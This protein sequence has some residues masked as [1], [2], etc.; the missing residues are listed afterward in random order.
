M[1]KKIKQLGKRLLGGTFAQGTPLYEFYHKG[2]GV[3]A[4]TSSGFPAAKMIVV[5]VTGTNG[6][7]A[8]CTMLAHIL[9]AAGKK[10]GLMT[11]VNFWINKKKWVNESKMTT[12]N[13]FT[14]QSLLRRMVKAGCE[15]AV[16]ETS[17]HALAQHRTWGI[18]YDVAVFTNLTQDHL[19]YHHTM[20]EYRRSKEKLFKN[21]ASSW[22]KPGVAKTIVL[23]FDDPLHA[24]FAKYPAE[25]KLFFSAQ[26]HQTPPDTLH[27]K[28]IH[29]AATGSLFTLVSPTGSIKVQLQIPGRFNI[30]NALAAAT[31]AYALGFPLADIKRGL[32]SVDLI[33]GRM[34]Y[35]KAGQPFNV[36]SDY[37][38]TPDGYEKSLSSIRQFTE[39][40][41]ITVFGAAGDRDKE[42]RPLIGR[43]A[44]KYADVIV[45]TEEDPGSEDP[46]Q[47]IEAIR[48]GISAEKFQESKNLFIILNRRAA[49]QHALSLAE[50]KDSVVLLALG[51]Q[52]KMATPTGLV[53]YDEREYAKTLLHKKY[54]S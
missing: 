48:A 26:N 6:K 23:N 35:I 28:E 42:K 15:Y 4:A 51:A 5:G 53:D 16:V 21:L 12:D 13:P 3:W 8:T 29:L 17:S 1:I 39:G 52:T 44:S 33:P 11:T 18:F 30:E 2:R 34:E 40:R 45:L 36:I 14:T 25:Q 43:I 31:S 7:T 24:H 19:D 37:A 10:V 32:E 49:V 41:V 20:E 9:E 46:G 38:H 54:S 27:A 22:K 50:K 47:I